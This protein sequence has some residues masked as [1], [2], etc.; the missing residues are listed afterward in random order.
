MTRRAASRT[1][2]LL[3]LVQMLLGPVVNFVL[4]KSVRA[5]VFL[6]EAA[7]NTAALGLGIVLGLAATAGSLAIAIVAWPIIG[8][9]SQAMARWLFA[10]AVVNLA[11]VALEYVGVFSMHALSVAYAASAEPATLAAVA[12]AVAAARIG[13]HFLG[14]VFAGSVAFALYSSL[15]RFAL[16]PRLIAGFGMLASLGE[17][18]A[19]AMPLF[20]ES[21]VFVLI[22]P[23]GVAH[24]ALM[25]WLLV[26]GL[27]DPERVAT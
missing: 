23:L 25:G 12:P 10:L 24:L 26:K 17:M 20:G 8:E 18:I 13:A 15:F 27:S 1:I 6:A 19:T 21:V 22:A 3:L 9:R 7:A 14:L 2:A 4:L 16:V 11:V 5:P